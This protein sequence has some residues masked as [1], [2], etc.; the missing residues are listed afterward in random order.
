MVHRYQTRR[1]RQLT[2]DGTMVGAKDFSLI[3]CFE[4]AVAAEQLLTYWTGGERNRDESSAARWRMRVRVREQVTTRA[5]PTGQPRAIK[6]ARQKNI[7]SG[8]YIQCYCTPCTYSL[9]I[10]C[11]HLQLQTIFHEE[12][13]RSLLLLCAMNRWR[14]SCW[15]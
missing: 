3:L 13:V 5:W 8:M 2:T 7:R 6:A 11:Y 12:S 9:P 15:F 14:N 1:G 4:R 10:S